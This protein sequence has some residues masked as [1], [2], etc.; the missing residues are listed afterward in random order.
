M[1]Q[2]PPAAKQDDPDDQ[3]SE[4]AV[5]Y[6]QQ[7]ARPG[8]TRRSRDCPAQR[9]DD[10]GEPGNRPMQRA[11]DR[12]VN[13]RRRV[14]GCK[15]RLDRRGYARH[16]GYAGNETSTR[17]SG[18]YSARIVTPGSV[19]TMPV[20]VPVVTK[21]PAGMPPR[22]FAT[23]FTSSTKRPIGSPARKPVHSANGLPSAVT[24]I[25]GWTRSIPCQPEA[26]A[27]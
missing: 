22:C 5:Q 8:V 12:I 27:P 6:Q 10:D 1:R 23:K 4:R 21:V 2:P 13:A 7:L 25:G 20:W 19:N 3:Q 15:P 18:P 14:A 11:R 26:A 17:P 16:A 9:D 24:A